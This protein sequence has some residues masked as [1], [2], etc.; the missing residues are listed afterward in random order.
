MK[1]YIKSL[2]IILITICNS[3]NMDNAN[4]DKIVFKDNLRNVQDSIVK[5]T[6]LLSKL[7][8]PVSINKGYNYKFEK[9]FINNKVVDN[10]NVYSI[11]KAQVLSA[12]TN[13][14]KLEF[15]NLSLYLKSNEI[16]SGYFDQYLGIWLFDYRYLPEAN[17]SDY[18]AIA[19]LK[20]EDVVR[21]RSSITI[22]DQKGTL[23]LLSFRKN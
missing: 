8:D 9:L 16:T 5:I 22:L 19:I 11:D 1:N 23:Y 7:Q 2:I 6:G 17:D 15:I 14:E 13:S 3:C 18:R 10:K 20:K 12:L 21:D 4:R